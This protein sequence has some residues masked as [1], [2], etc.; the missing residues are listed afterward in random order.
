M[1]TLG[2]PPLIEIEGSELTAD[3]SWRDFTDL[4]PEGDGGDGSSL[5]ESYE[6]STYAIKD[7]EQIV[8]LQTRPMLHVSDA[9]K[10]DVSKIIN[11]AKDSVSSFLGANPTPTDKLGMLLAVKDNLDSLLNTITSDK[12]SPYFSKSKK[13]IIHLVLQKLNGVLTEPI[14]IASQFNTEFPISVENLRDIDSTTHA[15]ESV[16]FED[17]SF[18]D[19]RKVALTEFTLLKTKLEDNLSSWLTITS[20]LIDVSPNEIQ[21][22]GFKKHEKGFY[23]PIREN[24]LPLIGIAV[25]I[26]SVASAYLVYHSTRLD[27]EKLNSLARIKLLQENLLK[28]SAQKEIACKANKDSD[29]CKKLTLEVSTLTSQIEHEKQYLENLPTDPFERIGTAFEK[30]SE[31]LKYIGVATLGLAV[32]WGVRKLL[33]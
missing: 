8:S 27:N 33:K 1:R 3:G 2:T 9:S 10:A 13:S 7:M 28:V 15:L 21:K 19:K 30:A 32:F 6:A 25:L 11:A 4:V 20:T 12:S 22:L 23:I 24:G 14:D 29:E 17:P 31:L 5:Q 16:T 26:F 18:E